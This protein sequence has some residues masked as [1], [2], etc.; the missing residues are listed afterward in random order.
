MRA[1]R[2]A[3]GYECNTRARSIWTLVCMVHL[4]HVLRVAHVLALGTTEAACAMRNA[5][6][7]ASDGS[8]L[9]IPFASP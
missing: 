7:I 1:V 5:M 2:E 4:H 3:E 8:P 6:L 9:K